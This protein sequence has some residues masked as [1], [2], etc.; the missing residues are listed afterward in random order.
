MNKNLILSLTAAVAVMFGYT[1]HAQTPATLTDLQGFNP[2]PSGPND[3]LVLDESNEGEPAG[4]NYY[5]DNGSPP[6]EIF[7]TPNT[8]PGGYVLTNLSVLMGGG[9]GGGINTF[10]QPYLL[11]I[12]SY[13][14]ANSNA[15]LLATYQSQDITYFTGDWLQWSGLNVGLVAN[16]YYAFSF[17]RGAQGWEMLAAE[18][19]DEYPAGQAVLIPK[20][21]GRLTA[22]ST[23]AG[24]D[25]NMDIGLLLAPFIVNAPTIAPA[26]VVSTGQSATIT[27]GS[28]LG[29]VSYAY[30]WQTDGGSGGALTNIPGATGSSITVSYNQIGVYNFDVVVTNLDTPSH[31]IATSASAALT[32][33]YPPAS[34]ALTDIGT[35]IVP[36]TYDISQ[37]NGGGSGDGLNY[38]DNNS[39]FPGQ[40]FTTGTNPAGYTLQTLAVKTG[41]GTIAG[42]N[43]AQPY[44]LFIYKVDPT[45][46]NAVVVQEYTNA[47]F[48]FAANGDWLQ[49]SGLNLFLAPTNKYAFAFANYNAFVFNNYYGY[50]QIDNSTTNSATTNGNSTYTGGELCLIQSAGGALF[51][52]LDHGS[53]TTCSAVFDVGLQGNGLTNHSTQPGSIQGAPSAPVLA[54]T[55]VMFTESAQ[56]DTPRHY[57]WKTDNGT[58][59]S[60]TAVGTDS[61]SL[62]VDTTGWAPGVYKYEVTVHNNY[63]PD[64]TAP[65]VSITILYANASGVLTDLGATAPTPGAND[66]YQLTQPTAQ[67]KPDGLNYY[68]DNS[69]PPGQTFTTGANSLGYVLKSV[70]LMMGGDVGGLPTNGQP[71][72]LRLYK[73]NGS[74]ATEYAIYTSQTNAQINTGGSGNDWLRWTGIAA[75]L[76]PSTTYAYTF[77]RD[78]SIGAGWDNVGNVGSNPYANGEVCLISAN[79]GTGSVVY[80]SSDSYD[81]TFDL[82][83]SLNVAISVQPVGSNLQLTWSAGAMLLQAPSLTGPWTTNSLATSPHT[84]TPSA[85]QQ[86]YRAQLP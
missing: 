65:A 28:V 70:S 23:V 63:G 30:Q 53:N 39:D 8:N 83:L 16:S 72:Y 75:P 69:Q 73:V 9:T 10:A 20:T 40:S 49:W 2:T 44:Y 82:G 79:G 67:N 1:S 46:S 32:V 17:N 3:I 71:Y 57:T 31:P 86:F 84:V 52:G 61:T 19:G 58:G 43:V 11:R 37:L 51:F 66:I 77:G 81:G 48:T 60:F 13:N 25:A 45:G 76:A 35:T 7:L 36:G 50:V 55:Q 29:A 74:T 12:Y 80:S 34:A 14:P 56:G 4:L 26:T 64:A 42:N 54:G 41:G 38:Y 27:S 47:S 62:A 5:V 22:F 59:G 24:W 15:T 68:M 21:G 18:S 85:G 78:Q 33:S 6:G